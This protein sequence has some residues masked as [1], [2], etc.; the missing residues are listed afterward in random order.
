MASGVSSVKRYALLTKHTVR[1]PLLPCYLFLPC[2]LSLPLLSCTLSR[3]LFLHLCILVWGAL[4]RGAP[5]KG[6]RSMMVLPPERGASGSMGGCI[7][8]GTQSK[9]CVL[10]LK[11]KLSLGEGINW[12]RGY[13]RQVDVFLGNNL[14]A[15]CVCLSP[16]A[17]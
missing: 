5:E 7:R 13:N 3:S 16:G 11:Q 6:V 1:L 15:L 2:Y 10:G 12:S 17:S 4:K 14:R 8:G 9:A